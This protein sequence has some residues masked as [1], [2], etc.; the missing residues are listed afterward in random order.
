MYKIIFKITKEKDSVIIHRC[1]IDA[2]LGM[3]YF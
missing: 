2:K 1:K 3:R